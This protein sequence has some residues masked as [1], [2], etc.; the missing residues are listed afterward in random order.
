M[1]NWSRSLVSRKRLVPLEKLTTKLP[2]DSGA[3]ISNFGTK[4]RWTRSASSG[5]KAL[6]T[7]A[8]NEVMAWRLTTELSGRYGL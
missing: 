6:S 7:G 2:K 8:G 3:N 5:P 1:K 4:F